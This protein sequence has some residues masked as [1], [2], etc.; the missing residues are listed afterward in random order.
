MWIGGPIER[1]LVGLRRRFA[2]RQFEAMLAR[3]PGAPKARRSVGAIVGWGLAAV[4]NLFPLALLIAGTLIIAGNWPSAGGIIWGGILAIVGIL[5]SLPRRWRLPDGLDRT[6]APALHG[7]VDEIADALGTRRVRRLA[8]TAEFNASY[9]ATGV[10]RRP[11]LV[12]GLP[13]WAVLSPQE[14]VAVLSHEFAHGTNRDGFRSGFMGRAAGTLAFLANATAPGS[15]GLILAPV[16]GAFAGLA[17][18]IVYLMWQRSQEAEFLADERGA[19]IAGTTAAVGTLQKT[20]FWRYMQPVLDP[21]AYRLPGS[22]RNFFPAF[23]RF[24]AGLPELERQRLQRL[25]DREAFEESGSHPPRWARARY[26]ES[27]PAP[28]SVILSPERSA[29]ID[30][31]TAR[32]EARLTDVL[33]SQFYPNR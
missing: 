29:A 32:L 10:R 4:V 18:L 15:D 13:L 30:A 14:R 5:L 17:Y 8:V 3:P 2:Q 27:R 7:L 22:D 31:E 11:V 6:D 20:G 1:R 16:S 26:L 21:I 24:I 12:I 33:L 19:A 23:R 28:G 25:M 9:I